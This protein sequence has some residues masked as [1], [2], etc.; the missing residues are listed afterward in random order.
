MGRADQEDFE[1]QN[2]CGMSVINGDHAE[3][4]DF[5]DTNFCNGWTLRQEKVRNF[6][7]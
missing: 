7:H 5:C 3:I 2:V 4:C 1:R 6:K